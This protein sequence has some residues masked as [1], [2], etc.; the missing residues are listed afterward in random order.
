MTRITINLPLVDERAC[1]GCT[2]REANYCPAFR[3]KEGWPKKLRYMVNV[4]SEHGFRYKRLPECLA[5]EVEE[6]ERG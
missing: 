6:V 1:Q 3:T 4:G 2:V 5:A